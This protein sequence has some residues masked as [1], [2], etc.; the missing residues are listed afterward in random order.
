MADKRF[1][2]GLCDYSS[3]RKWNLD[4]HKCKERKSPKYKCRFC[5]YSSD[6]KWNRDHHELTC[7]HRE[8]KSTEQ[9]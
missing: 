9:L 3:D 7:K 6:R 4:Q 1:K 5:D 8:R 2:C